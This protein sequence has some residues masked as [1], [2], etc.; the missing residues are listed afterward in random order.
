[1]SRQ[2]HRQINT[3]RR[4]WAKYQQTGSVRDLRRRPRSKVTTRPQDRYIVLSH[5]RDR[6][7]SATTTARATRGLHGRFISSQTVRNRLREANLRAR[8]PQRCLVL[9][10]RHKRERMAWARRHL[11]FTR[12]DWANVLFVDETKIKLKGPDGRTR[13]YRRRGERQ[14][15]NCIDEVDRFGG[16]ASIMMWA[17]ISMHTKTPIIRVQGRLTAMRYQNDIIRPV[18]I[19]HIAGNRGMILAQDNAP[20]HAARVNQQHLAANNIRVLPWPAK[21]PDLNP[22]EHIWDLLKRSIKSLPQAQTVQALE[23]RTRQIWQQITQQTI[24]GYI[25]SMR[26]RCLAVIRA[27]GGHTE[28]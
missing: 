21:S 19:P 26:K 14:S 25:Q 22:I 28:Y 10:Q 20:C 2:F 12:A 3:I 18:I 17:G 5:L 23:Q 6:F 7:K 11:R 13:V 9:T 16:G 1:M 24:Q 4:L 15:A 8:R 27:Q